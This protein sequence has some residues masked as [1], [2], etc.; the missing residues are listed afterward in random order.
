MANKVICAWCRKDCI[1]AGLWINGDGG[2]SYVCPSGC[3]ATGSVQIVES[4]VLKEKDWDMHD[5]DVTYGVVKEIAMRW[6]DEIFG[7]KLV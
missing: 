5:G 1:R 4:T 7:K 2:I 3:T 6:I